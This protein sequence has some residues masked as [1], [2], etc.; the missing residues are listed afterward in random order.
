MTF[1]RQPQQNNQGYQGYQAYQ[2]PD[3]YQAQG[4]RMYGQGTG[5]EPYGS[6]YVRQPDGTAAIPTHSPY[7]YERAERTSM[8]RAYA[9]MGLGLLV[10]AAVAYLAYA[11]GLLYSFVSATGS[12]G[13]VALCIAQIAFAW[14]LSARVMR[15]KTS[16]GR[17]MFY[18]YAALMGFTLSSLF[19]AYSV[20][21]LLVTLVTCSAFFFV[22]TMLGLTTRKNMLGWGPVLFAGLISLLLVQVVLMFI[23]PSASALKVIATIG[24]ALFAGITM[25]DAQQT[26]AIFAAYESQGAAA[27]ERVSI[28]C[29]LNLYLDFVNLFLYIIQLFGSRN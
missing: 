16:T 15:M 4:Q 18:A 6:P 12:L 8:T 24:I 25:H 27:I 29:A 19:A 23:A 28:L 11:S 21:T 14:T 10:T 17:I 20:A 9:E 22:L 13:W 5:Q 7:S 3:P 2:T 26:R 1:G